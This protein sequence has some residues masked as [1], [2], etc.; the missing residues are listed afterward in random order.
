MAP[1]STNISGVDLPFDLFSPN[2]LWIAFFCVV[3]VFFFYSVFLV[4]H[5]FRYGMNILVSL[6]ATAIYV[7]VSLGILLTMLLSFASLIP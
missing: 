4:Y 6:L 2:T 1:F 5:W 7:T 3:V